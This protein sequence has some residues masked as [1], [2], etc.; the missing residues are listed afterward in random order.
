M[1]ANPHDHTDELRALEGPRPREPFFVCI[2][3]TTGSAY[4][5]VN[6]ELVQMPLNGWVSEQH[7]QFN[8]NETGEVDF[9]RGVAEEDRPHMVAIRTSLEVLDGVTIP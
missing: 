2:D 4:R 6:D 8:I 3:P 7:I 5:Y 1:S 9:E